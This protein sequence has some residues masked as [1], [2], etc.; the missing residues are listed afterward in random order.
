V[1]TGDP[2]EDW[3]DVRLPLGTAAELIDADRREA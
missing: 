3:P 2:F 1:E